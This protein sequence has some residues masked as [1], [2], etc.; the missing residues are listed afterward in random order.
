MVL[1]FSGDIR[2]YSGSVTLILAAWG[3]ISQLVLI[4]SLNHQENH[5]PPEN[6]PIVLHE[7]LSLSSLMFIPISL[8]SL[9]PFHSHV[10]R[11]SLV[12]SHVTPHGPTLHLLQRLRR[13]Q[14]EQHRR[15]AQGAKLDGSLLVIF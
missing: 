10:N 15:G 5:M 11:R 1:F 6:R 4:E 8:G 2:S 3:C 7:S 12:Q 14:G 13:V 9:A